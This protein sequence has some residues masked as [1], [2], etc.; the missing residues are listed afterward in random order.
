VTW[1]PIAI[2][3]GLLL[4]GLNAL[5][6]RFAVHVD[7]HEPMPRFRLFQYGTLVSGDTNTPEWFFAWKLPSYEWGRIDWG[8]KEGWLQRV[9]FWADRRGWQILLVPIRDLE[10]E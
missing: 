6:A 3:G 2:L 1:M 5:I 4:E 7:R 9:V 8:R 10:F